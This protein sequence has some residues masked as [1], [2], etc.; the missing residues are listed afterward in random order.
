MV[1]VAV[2]EFQVQMAKYLDQVMAGEV[3]VLTSRGRAA[4]DGHVPLAES[5][6]QPQPTRVPYPTCASSSSVAA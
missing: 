2:S 3:V 1:K 6:F 5:A 4:L